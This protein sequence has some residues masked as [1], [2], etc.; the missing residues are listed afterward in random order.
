MRNRFQT[1]RALT[2]AREA[3]AEQ[4]LAPTRSRR[5]REYVCTACAIPCRAAVGLECG[6]SKPR[7]G[8]RGVRFI[9]WPEHARVSCCIA[10]GRIGVSLRTHSILKL[11][12]GR[13][14]RCNVMGLASRL[15]EVENR[16]GLGVKRTGQRTCSERP[17]KQGKP[18]LPTQCN[19]VCD[20]LVCLGTGQ[21]CSSVAKI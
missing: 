16:P 2:A 20:N 9:S 13:K 1:S 19:S 4:F 14:M 10:P 12:V 21:A 11:R 18:D 5:R 17:C 15:M 8:A 3:A 6:S 7:K